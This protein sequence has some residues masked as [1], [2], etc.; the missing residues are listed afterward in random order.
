M[1]NLS[2]KKIK[3]WKNLLA[4][5]QLVYYLTF[6]KLLKGACIDKFQNILK[7]IKISMWFPSEKGT[8]VVPKIV[9]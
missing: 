9:Y 8:G 5:D 2:I 6:Q 4:I 3:A 7:L 1:L